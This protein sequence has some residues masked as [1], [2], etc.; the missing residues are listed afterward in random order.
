[1]GTGTY[2]SHTAPHRATDT[3]S[4]AADGGLQQGGD[5]HAEE[6][7]A[8]QL[9]RGPLVESHTHGL[10]EEEGHSDGPAEAC[11]VVLQRHG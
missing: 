5:A 9:A 1:M 3:R 2:Q 7:G 11:Q 8:D 10:R 6:D 4:P